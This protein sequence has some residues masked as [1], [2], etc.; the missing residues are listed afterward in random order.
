MMGELRERGVK[1]HTQW[2]FTDGFDVNTV[3]CREQFRAES[4]FRVES[5]R[6]GDGAALFVRMKPADAQ[7]AS[8]ETFVEAQ[9]FANGVDNGT[10][11]RVDDTRGNY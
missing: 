9:E 2:Q 4:V 7:D 5:I 10:I 6:I 11:V 3:Q 8:G 1:R